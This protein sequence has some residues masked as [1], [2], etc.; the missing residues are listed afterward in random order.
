MGCSSMLRLRCLL[1]VV[2]RPGCKKWPLRH[3]R[4]RYRRYHSTHAHTSA[5]ERSR[6]QCLLCTSD[7][8][9]R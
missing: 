3:R 8:G 1:R 5:W 2:L 7:A 4:R 9:L 6:S